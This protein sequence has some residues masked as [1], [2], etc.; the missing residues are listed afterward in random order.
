M[1]TR[2]H[3]QDRGDKRAGDKNAVAV[4]LG[5]GSRDMKSVLDSRGMTG[6][7]NIEDSE[8]GTDR[9]EKRGQGSKS[10]V[11]WTGHVEH[12]NRDWTSMAGQP[13]QCSRDRSSVT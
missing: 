13:G 12:D 6:Q 1:R 11:L 4:K 9:T 7:T 3:R 10:I 8:V 2:Q 5:K